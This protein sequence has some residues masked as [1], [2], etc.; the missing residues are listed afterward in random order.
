M[1]ILLTPAIR[2]MQRL[3]LLPKFMLVCL[4]FLLPL[5]L[6]TTLLIAELGKSLSQAQEAQGGVRYV[7]QLQESTRLLQ[8]R[9]GEEHLRLSMKRAVDSGAT[10][11]NG[12]I[13]TALQAL[14]A[15]PSGAGL[16]QVAEML[17]QW[18]ALLAGQASLGAKESY[19]AHTALIRQAGKLLQ[20]VADRSH[21][22]LD[23]EAGASHLSNVYTGF[24]PDMA[25][26]LSDI[27]GRGGAYIDTGLFEANEDQLVNATAQIARHDLERLPA[28]FDEIISSQPALKAPLEPALKALPAALA[29]LDRT[30]NEVT[31]SYEQTSGAAFHKAGMQA[32]DGLYALAATSGDA[33]QAVLAER[34]ARD[35]ARRALILAAML[36]VLAIAAYL[37]AGFYASFSRDVAQLRLAVGA[38]AAGDLSHRIDS[39]ARDEIGDL[40]RDFGAMTRGLATLVQEIRGGAAVIATAG[41]DMAQ[42]NQA[43]SGHTATQSEAL[44]ATVDSMRELTATVGRNE[45]HVAQGSTL[46]ASA[47]DVA[48]RGGETVTAVVDTMASIKASSHKIVDIIGVINGIAFQTNILALNAAVEAARAGEQGRGFA[49][50]AAEVRSLAQRSN[51]AA[52]EIKR[53]IGDSVATVD[54]GGELVNAAGSTMRQVVEAVQQV[55]V[56]IGR[57]S[58]AGAEQNGEIAQINGA[59]AQIDDMTRQNAALVEEARIGAQRLHEEGEALTQAVSRFRLEETAQLAAG[60]PRQGLPSV[61][62]AGSWS[63]NKPRVIAQNYAQRRKA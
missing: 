20:L 63:A 1:K 40:V 44:G 62:P 35:Q 56:V 34:I 60:A 19:T 17:K 59:L 18:Q 32:I 28:R 14:Q 39:A 45:A 48:R 7:H 8:Q 22:N 23:G 4:V 43:L 25:E 51:E 58:S 27:A 33:L 52:L 29:F 42:G 46:V 37:C 38:A 30:K 53:L 50:V 55:A 13:T 21:M 3:R 31:N 57:I 36:L 2:L 61:R 54:A 9:R 16:P 6:V 12:K 47:A 26:S 11:R 5:A 10:A 15:S 24:L 41:A 49:V